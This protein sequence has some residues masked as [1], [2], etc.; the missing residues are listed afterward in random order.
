MKSTLQKHETTRVRKEGF[1]FGTAPKNWGLNTDIEALNN[2][3]LVKGM[4]REERDVLLKRLS[5]DNE[6]NEGK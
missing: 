3:F 2:V 6:S 1:S 5:D 4:T